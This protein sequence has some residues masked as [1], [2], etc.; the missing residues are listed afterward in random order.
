MTAPAPI[1]KRECPCPENLSNYRPKVALASVKDMRDF[2]AAGH[3]T[4]KT[5][6][7][8]IY[9]VGSGFNLQ[10]VHQA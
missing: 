7:Y 6:V 1:G 9:A 2:L 4:I 8:S 3:K 10:P 5:A